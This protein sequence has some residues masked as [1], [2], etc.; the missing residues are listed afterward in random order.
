MQQAPNHHLLTSYHEILRKLEQPDSLLNEEIDAVDQIHKSILDTDHLTAD[1]KKRLKQE[2]TGYGPLDELLNREDLTEI[3]ING[4][5]EI[6][7]EQR[8]QIQRHPEGFLCPHSYEQFL[9]R[10]SNEAQLQA[11]LIDPLLTAFGIVFASTCYDH[12]WSLEKLT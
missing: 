4:H 9:L 12:H 2:M 1:E 8:G 10:M 11:N 5:N 7:L 6:W 3:M